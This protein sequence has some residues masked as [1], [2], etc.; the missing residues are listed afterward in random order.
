M[1]ID[2]SVGGSAEFAKMLAKQKEDGNISQEELIKL[3]HDRIDGLVKNG[4]SL[5]P[6]GQALQQQMQQSQQTTVTETILQKQERSK[7]SEIIDRLESK[8]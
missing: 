8:D 2:N 3:L 4:E 6:L 1:R 5:K 7:S